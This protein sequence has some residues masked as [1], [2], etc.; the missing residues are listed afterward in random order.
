M[1]QMPILEC[2]LSK[3][4]I[5]PH[6]HRLIVYIHKVRWVFQLRSV[7]QTQVPISLVILVIGIQDLYTSK[8]KY[9]IMIIIVYWLYY[10]QRK[11]IFSLSFSLIL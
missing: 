11:I 6:Y 7:F 4:N 3:F 2:Y 5:Q 10:I 8:Y 9:T 1:N